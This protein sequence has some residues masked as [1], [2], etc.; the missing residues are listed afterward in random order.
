MPLS[1]KH[2]L[3][4]IITNRRS[5][6]TLLHSQKKLMAIVMQA[7]ARMAALPFFA[8]CHPDCLGNDSHEHKGATRF[9]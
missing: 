3:N 2:F 4:S 1:M 7:D 6:Q 5:C 8:L 9:Q